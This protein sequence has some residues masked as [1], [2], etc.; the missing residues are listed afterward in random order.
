MVYDNMKVAVKRFVGTE[1]EPIEG[2]L[3][4]S[5]YY[6]FRYRFCNVRSGNEEGHVERSVEVSAG[7]RSRFGIRL[8]HWMRP[9]RI[10]LKCH[11]ADTLKLY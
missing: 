9:M 7:Q 2:L 6:G 11:P 10:C 5:I 1:K 8:R 3:Q 4:L